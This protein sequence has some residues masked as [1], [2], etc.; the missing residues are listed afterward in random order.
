MAPLFKYH[1]NCFKTTTGHPPTSQEDY[2]GQTDQQHIMTSSNGND[3]RNATSG[4]QPLMSGNGD[5]VVS[6]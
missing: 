1:F 5:Y 6:Y 3:N 2:T 4:F